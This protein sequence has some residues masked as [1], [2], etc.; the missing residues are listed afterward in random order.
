MNFI[1]KR[2]EKRKK[3][4]KKN[5]KKKIKKKRKKRK[6]NNISKYKIVSLETTIWCFYYTFMLSRFFFLDFF[7]PDIT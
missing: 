7:L 2:K 6:I 5:N 4:R 3:R 1:F